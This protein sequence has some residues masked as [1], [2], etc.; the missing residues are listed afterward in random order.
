MEKKDPPQSSSCMI[1][2]TVYHIL[3]VCPMLEDYRKKVRL[4]SKC[5]KWIL[6]DNDDIASQV[7][8]FLR[9][10]KLFNKM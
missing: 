1:P 8:R 9:I 10:S 7:I 2:L 6:S 3:S 5:L 4:R